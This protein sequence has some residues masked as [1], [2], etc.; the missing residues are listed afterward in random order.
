MSLLLVHMLCVDLLVYLRRVCLFVFER[1]CDCFPERLTTT[2]TLLEIVYY[3]IACVYFL[4]ELIVLLVSL[5]R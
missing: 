3:C 2:L 4:V 1:L 5:I